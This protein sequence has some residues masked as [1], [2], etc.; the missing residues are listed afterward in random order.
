ME[1]GITQSIP[2]K[3]KK[4]IDVFIYLQSLTSQNLWIFN[5]NDSQNKCNTLAK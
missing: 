3:A 4:E 5:F 1:T 2:A